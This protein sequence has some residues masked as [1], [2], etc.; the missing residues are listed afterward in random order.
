MKIWNEMINGLGWSLSRTRADIQQIIAD[1]S[2]LDPCNPD[3]TSKDILSD[4]ADGNCSK[5]I[6]TK[7]IDGILNDIINSWNIEQ[8]ISCLENNDAF[9]IDGGPYGRLNECEKKLVRIYPSNAIVILMN[10]DKAEKMTA[11]MFGD[12]FRNEC[13]DA[14][15]HALFNAMNTSSCGSTFAKKF[16]DAH[17]CDTPTSRLKEKE[18][19]LFN[20]AIG[21]EIAYN[22]MGLTIEIY[23]DLICEK[24][25]NGELMVL[26][27]PP[28]PWSSTLIQSYG[29]KCK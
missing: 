15:R 17:E 22:N 9:N 23:A 5:D 24:L 19:D 2:L 27:D 26:S 16:G 6:C 3:L 11:Q 10:K 25:A 7:S 1:N 21:L 20:N 28:N 12:N 13:S 14:F 29:C 18:M 8:M 4:Y